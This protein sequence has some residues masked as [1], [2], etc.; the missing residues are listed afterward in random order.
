[1]RSGLHSITL[2]GFKTVHLL[3]SF[4]LGPLTVLIGPN[5]AGKSNLISFFRMM[6][7]MLADPNSLRLHVA[8]QGGASKLL[9]NGPAATRQIESELTIRTDAGEN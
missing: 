8:R 7:S 5:G 2:K 3:E 6:S 1:M 4:E 9:H